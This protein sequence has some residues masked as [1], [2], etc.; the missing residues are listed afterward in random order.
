MKFNL[1]NV[2]QLSA[3]AKTNNYQNFFKPSLTKSYLKAHR[4]KLVKKKKKKISSEVNET[5]VS[6]FFKIIRRS[7]VLRGE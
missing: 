3:V 1:F 7:Q 4:K 5:G 6:G 2:L